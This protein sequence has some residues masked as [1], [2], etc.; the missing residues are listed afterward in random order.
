MIGL[1][2]AQARAEVL[3]ASPSPGWSDHILSSPCIRQRTANL[4][5]GSSLLRSG[6]RYL[7]HVAHYVGRALLSTMARS[8][9]AVPP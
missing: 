6:A 8:R 2:E 9:G 3:W 4:V 5:S 7:P 1:V